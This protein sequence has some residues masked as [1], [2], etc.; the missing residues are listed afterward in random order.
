MIQINQS[1]YKF[2][3][4]K[5]KLR[6]KLFGCYATLLKDCIYAVTNISVT[7]LNGY[8]NIYSHESIFLYQL[9]ACSFTKK[10][11]LSEA[12]LKNFANRFSWQ[13]YRTA[14]LK[15]PFSIR[16]L[17]VAASVYANNFLKTQK[18]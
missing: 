9:Y 17:S 8:L 3:K 11:I 6:G 10:G 13:N 15:E 16:T 4:Q 7:N 5:N 1:Q 2:S 14:I 12:F 18:K